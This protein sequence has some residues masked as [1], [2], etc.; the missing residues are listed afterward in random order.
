MIEAMIE[1]E[2]MLMAYQRVVQNKGAA[3]IDGMR[4]EE[5]GQYLQEHWV[6]IR[7]ALL[8]GRYKPQ[9][10]RSVEIP[11][12]SGGMRKLGIP[13]VVDRLIQ[14]ALL[15][16]LSPV[17]EPEFSNYSYGYRP[18]RSATDAVRQAQQYIGCGNRWVVD[19][20]IET[21][22]DR[23]NHDIL[24]SRVAAKVTD[25]RVLKLLRLYLQSGVL[26]DG[27]VQP[28]QQGTPQGSPLSPLL[29]NI[30]LDDL[31]KELERRGHHFCRYADD[32]N[33][34]VQSQQ[35]GLRVKDSISRW[36][37]KKLRL[38][39]NE[40]KSAVDRPWRRKFLGYTVTAERQTRLRVAAASLR[41]L[42]TSIRQRLRRSASLAHLIEDLRPRLRGW[43]NYFRH[44]EVSGVF[45]QLDSWIRRRLR[46]KL[47]RQWK[48]PRTRLKMLI[49]HGLKPQR[50]ASSAYNGRGPWWNSGASHM[51][52]AL[53][54]CFFEQRGLLS[55]LD[56]YRLFQPS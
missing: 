6:S 17:F 37:W 54:K 7:I 2:N 8:E 25:K 38:R 34:Y 11:K 12:P 52:L 48:R 27:L 53:P 40:S 43:L 9:A 24:M 36:L 50:A 26:Q 42:Q 32:C 39:V 22:F 33:M 44:A 15:Q 16:V 23:V 30:L 14:Q 19:I 20:D 31:D 3:G 51:N 21:F 5:L 29:S 45:E 4:V 13:T 47:W 56:Q 28:R 10:V 49:R 55:L 41:K 35:A 46:L 18:G 1:R